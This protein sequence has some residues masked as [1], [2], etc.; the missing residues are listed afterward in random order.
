VNIGS[1]NQSGNWYIDLVKGGSRA[2]Q[3][4]GLLVSVWI[5]GQSQTPPQQQQAAPAQQQQA[6]SPT[7]QSG[8]LMSQLNLTQDQVEKIKAIREEQKEARKAVNRRVQVARRALD[9][10]IY[11]NDPDDATVE[12]RARELADAQA[13][14]LRLQSIGELRIRRVLTPEQ[15]V[16]FRELRRQARQA[17]AERRR[18]Q[19]AAVNGARSSQVQ[20]NPLNRRRMDAPN[21][22]SV[23]GPQVKGGTATGGAARPTNRLN[24]PA[25]RPP[26]NP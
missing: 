6:T 7:A 15:L 9:E 26:G 13:D 25:R 5:A 21:K 11:L 8:E 14:A 24:E 19:S 17:Q 22:N 3:A 2:L 4:C 20:L 1:M 12:A 16:T 10:A 23:V 18:D